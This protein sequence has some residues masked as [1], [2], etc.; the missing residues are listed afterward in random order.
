M[1]TIQAMNLPLPTNWQDFE[2]IVRDAQAQRWS[3]ANLSM[4]GRS[5]QKQHGVDI[6]GPD[7]IGRPVGI[8]CKR[9]KGA[10]K[11]ADITDEVTKAEA[12]KGR[13]TTLYV[14]TT[15][16]YDAPLSEQ[17]RLL[18]DARV[19]AGKFAVSLLHWN[20]IVVGLSLNPAVF[21]LHYP[22]IVLD[23]P[24]TADRER[25]LA[26]L[27]L[28]YYGADLWAAI[29]LIYGEFGWMAQADPD[30]LIGMLRVL[31]KRTEQL[32]RPDDAGPILDGLAAVR[33]GCLKTKSTKADWDPVEVEAKRV[34]KR[35]KAASSLLP[36][37]ESNVLDLGLQL[38]RLYHH[39]DDRP[40]KAVRKAVR[41][42]VC[43]VLPQDSRATIKRKF[44][45]ARDL[46]SG[47]RWAM[48]IFTLLDNE[49]RYR[50]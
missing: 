3:S 10:L 29:I 40:A 24:A 1:P 46:K 16:D 23:P 48:A 4:N 15:A 42:K 49:I 6:Y 25:M 14:A 21:R 37:V 26:A 31:E 22:Q 39:A 33:T 50:F 20:E 5:G 27:E 36:I 9:F 30:E 17:V 12:F 18:S 38:G 2:A 34:S 35:L 32:L 28:G 13:L 19:V 44:R 45:T 11:L 41:A 8:Q 47:Y 43:S 7:D